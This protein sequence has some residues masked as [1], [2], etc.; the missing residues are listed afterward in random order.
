MNKADVFRPSRRSVLGVGAAGLLASVL[1]TAARAG[2]WDQIDST[3]ENLVWD[4]H[5]PSI[6]VAIAKNGVIVHSRYIGTANLETGTPCSAASIYRIGS[7]SKQFTAAGLLLLQEDGKLSLDDSL[8]RYMPEFPRAN[9]ITLR[10]MATHTSGLGNYTDTETPQEFLQR[11]R[12]D[13][14]DPALLEWLGESD[15]LYTSEPGTEWAYSNTAYVLLGMVMTQVSGMEYGDFLNSRLFAPYDLRQT[16]V[17]NAGMVVRDRVNGYTPAPSSPTGFAN[18]SFISMMIPGAAGAMTSSVTD[19]CHWHQLLMAGKIL[20][21]Q[22][23][24]QFTTPGR[25]SN[26]ALPMRGSGADATPINYGLGVNVGEGDYGRTISHGGGIQGFISRLASYPD[27]GLTIAMT[28]NC[29]PGIV[30]PN[31]RLPEGMS[32]AQTSFEERVKAIRSAA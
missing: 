10:Q 9:E 4:R 8:S 6:A 19:L 12:M 14:D 20:K 1:P 30:D 22:S 17:D 7:V 21:P 5:T 24:Q 18:A 26:G 29:D 31:L 2:E 27:A 23:F 32:A 11:S 13:L 3:L 25:L 28:T 15:P 16:S